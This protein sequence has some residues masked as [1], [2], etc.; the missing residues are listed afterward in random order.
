[1]IDSALII[2]EAIVM[3]YRRTFHSPMVLSSSVWVTVTSK[4]IIARNPW[5]ISGGRSFSKSIGKSRTL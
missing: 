3:S 5:A 4:V 2:L 1:M